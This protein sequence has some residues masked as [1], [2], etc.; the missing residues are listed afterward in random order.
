[1]HT[2]RRKGRLGSVRVKLVEA[3]THLR[4]PRDRLDADDGW[5]VL[6]LRPLI[7]DVH[8]ECGAGVL[9]MPDP[10]HRPRRLHRACSF[11]SARGGSGPTS[12]ARY[13]DTS[14]SEVIGTLRCIC[15]AHS[16]VTPRKVAG[17]LRRRR[18]H[19]IRVEGGLRERAADG[20]ARARRTHWDSRGG[21]GGRNGLIAAHQ[22]ARDASEL[23]QALC[24]RQG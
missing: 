6:V 3:S 10:R 17:L 23:S 18:A 14:A 7:G 21:R 5:R 16:A 1:M 8:V 12:R 11:Q 19:R 13:S 4:R 20:V 22:R 9:L 24:T 15:G 2:R